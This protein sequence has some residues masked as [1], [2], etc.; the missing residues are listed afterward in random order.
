MMSIENG[1]VRVVI[2]E[3]LPF[4]P[5]WLPLSSQNEG[6]VNGNLEAFL[7]AARR[8]YGNRFPEWLSGADNVYAD[9][10]SRCSESGIGAMQASVGATRRNKRAAA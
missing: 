2:G 8:L 10:L 1:D 6:K 3:H 9:K 4:L 5:N 7:Q